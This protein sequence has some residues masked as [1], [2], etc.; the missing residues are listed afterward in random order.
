MGKK[1]KD[2]QKYLKYLKRRSRKVR[3]IRR[4]GK[5]AGLRKFWTGEPDG[6]FS[7][8]WDDATGATR[9]CVNCQRVE[10]MSHL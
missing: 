6:C 3:A 10:V 4:N 2:F 5:L 8:E 1:M 9:V 7:C